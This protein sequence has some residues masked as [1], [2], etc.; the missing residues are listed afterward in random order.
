MLLHSDVGTYNQRYYD[1]HYLN[2][3]KSTFGMRQSSFGLEYTHADPERN[4]T[5]VGFALTDI[6][7][8]RV[9]NYNHYETHPST[10]VMVPYMFAGYGFDYFGCEL[11]I[12]CY[13]QFSREDARLYYLEDGSEIEDEEAG[14]HLDRKHS[15]TFINAKI[16]LFKEDSVHC[17]ITMGRDNFDPVDSLVNVAVVFPVTSHRFEF[18]LSFLTLDNYLYTLFDQDNVLKSNQTTGL[19]Y[20]CDFG[21]ISLG[22]RVG[23]LIYN[24]NGGDGM[25]P[26]NRRFNGGVFTLLKW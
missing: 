13:L 6:E 26:L 18:Y 5:G 4:S 9:W 17:R 2:N 7:K 25:V 1:L 10:M 14:M 12:S 19:C 20:S 8:G 22:V 15:H 3:N 24:A 16:R 21:G 11:G 23:V